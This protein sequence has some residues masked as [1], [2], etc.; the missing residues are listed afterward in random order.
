MYRIQRP[1]ACTLAIVVI[2][3]AT[4]ALLASVAVAADPFDT[5]QWGNLSGRLYFDGVVPKPQEPGVFTDVTIED[6]SLIVASDSS[7]KNVLVY[8]RTK[9]GQSVDIHPMYARSA[10]A[11]VPFTVRGYQFVPHIGLLR[12]TQVLAV[13]NED[14]DFDAVRFPPMKNSVVSFLLPAGEKQVRYEWHRTCH[15][16]FLSRRYEWHRVTTTVAKTYPLSFP[17]SET[18]PISVSSLIHPWMRSYVLV[19]DN[20][21]MAVTDKFGNFR[22]EGLPVGTHEFQLWHERAG[23]LRNVNVKGRKASSRGRF[24]IEIKSGENDLGNIAVPASL[25]REDVRRR[26]PLPVPPRKSPPPPRTP[27]ARTGL[28]TE[29]S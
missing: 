15:R 6:H 9:R 11:E 19:R 8:L 1:S 16:R 12:T 7:I 13:T 2:T 22:I 4:M 21:Y 28:A 24:K 14:P 3:W 20:P 5:L 23:Y 10:T 27:L 17:N 26:V 29:Q 18:I 25:L